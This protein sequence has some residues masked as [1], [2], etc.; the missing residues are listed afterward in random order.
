MNSK[1]DKIELLEYL[2]EELG[3]KSERF[4]DVINSNQE[5]FSPL[6]WY[7]KTLA[8]FPELNDNNVDRCLYEMRE[9]NKK[10]DEIL[11]DCLSEE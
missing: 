6:E 5:K 4:K 3:V 8:F 10:F 1:Q 9:V 2:S 7:F 11:F